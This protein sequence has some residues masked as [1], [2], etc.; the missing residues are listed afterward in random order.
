MNGPAEGTTNRIYDWLPIFTQVLLG[1]SRHKKSGI[2]EILNL[3][4]LSVSSTEKPKS[5][6]SPVA[7]I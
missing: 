2:W 6:V 4:M 3:S 5:H 7:N 1:L